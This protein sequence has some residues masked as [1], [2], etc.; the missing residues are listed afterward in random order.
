MKRAVSMKTAAVV[1]FLIAMAACS[2]DG[3][4]AVEPGKERCAQCRMDLVDMR[5]DSQLVTTKGRRY[6]FDSIECMVGWMDSHSDVAVNPDRIY[7]KNV[8]APDQFLDFNKARFVQ[9]ERLASPMGAFLAAYATDDEVKQSI[10]EYG[11]REL[12]ADELHKAIENREREHSS[13]EH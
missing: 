6:Y 1:L 9:S 7:V 10:A 13:H 3:P 11:G 5:F 12:K 2:P 4:V 8:A